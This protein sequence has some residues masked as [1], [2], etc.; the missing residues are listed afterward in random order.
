MRASRSGGPP[1]SRLEVLCTTNGATTSQTR[2]KRKEQWHEVVVVV[3]HIVRDM[4][5][6]IQESALRVGQAWVLR[7]QSGVWDYDGSWRA[8]SPLRGIFSTYD[9]LF[10]IFPFFLS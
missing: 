7:V 1:L 9:V 10:A 6:R 5:G 4:I 2:Q 8:Q 3:L